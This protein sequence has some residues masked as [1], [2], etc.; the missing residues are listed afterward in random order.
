[1]ALGWYSST[2]ET[3][4][5]FVF[6]DKLKIFSKRATKEEYGE[7]TKLPGLFGKPEVVMSHEVESREKVFRFDGKFPS[8]IGLDALNYYRETVRPDIYSEYQSLLSS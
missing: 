4:I 2:S 7:L 8:R 3:K 5:L 1:M 6:G